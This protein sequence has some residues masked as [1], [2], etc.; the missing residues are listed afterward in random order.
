MIHESNKQHKPTVHYLSQSFLF[1][2]LLS[3]I[4]SSGNTEGVPKYGDAEKILV[5]PL[6]WAQGRN[7]MIE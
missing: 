7:N 4:E 3:E 6:S 5:Q 2:V 1:L